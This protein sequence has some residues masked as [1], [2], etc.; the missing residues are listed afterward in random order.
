MRDVKELTRK[1]HKKFEM[2]KEKNHKYEQGESS[3]CY[4]HWYEMRLKMWM[5]RGEEE[6]A[7]SEKVW[8]YL[9]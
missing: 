1:A 5:Y 3:C 9:T 6:A 2:E 7:A 4:F 8:F